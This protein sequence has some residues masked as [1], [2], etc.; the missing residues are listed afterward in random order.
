MEVS[1]HAGGEGGLDSTGIQN[2]SQN[3]VPGDGGGGS[4]IHWLLSF[5][6]E[7]CRNLYPSHS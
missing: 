7:G 1:F 2:A 6:A 5:T 3:C 4:P